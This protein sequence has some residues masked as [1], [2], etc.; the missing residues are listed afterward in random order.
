MV[1]QL[2]SID[3]MQ[4]FFGAQFVALLD[5]SQCG[6]APTATRAHQGP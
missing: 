2:N 4:F 3:C 1:A 5:L 6:L